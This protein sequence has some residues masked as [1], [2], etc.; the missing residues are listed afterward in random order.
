MDVLG[1]QRAPAHRRLGP[2]ALREHVRHACSESGGELAEEGGEILL[3]AGRDDEACL[4][5]VRAD[6]DAEALPLFDRF[7]LEARSIR[8]AH[9]P[10][11]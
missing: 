7:D 10:G 8:V 1:Q 11:R 6:D 9:G 2:L 4:L 3:R 5:P